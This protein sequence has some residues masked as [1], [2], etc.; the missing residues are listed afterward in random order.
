VY[1]E[2]LVVESERKWIKITMRPVNPGEDRK[3]KKWEQT[4][5]GVSLGGGFTGEFLRG[6]WHL[7]LRQAGCPSSP[8]KPLPGPR[9]QFN[10]LRKRMIPRPVL[11]RVSWRQ[12]VCFE[13]SWAKACWSVTG[14][15]SMPGTKLEQTG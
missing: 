3:K 13:A 5:S 9:W 14:R 12:V 2:C 15:E 4:V 1:L 7:E 8:R 6:T 11:K 10:N